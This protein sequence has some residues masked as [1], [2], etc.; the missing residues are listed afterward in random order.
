MNLKGAVTIV[1]G[2][3]SG[4]GAAA[5]ERLAGKGCRVVV[6]YSKSADGAEQ[7]AKK[8]R[9]AGSEAIVVKADVA[10]DGDCRRLAQAALDKWGRIDALI[11]NAGTTKF[12]S[13]ADLDALDAAD[14]Q[15]IYAVNVIGTYQMT[16]AVAPAMKKA[17]H[18]AVVN[19]S[20]IASTRGSGSS[21][22]YAA[23]KGALNT[24]TIG[25]ARSLAPEI[26]VNAILPGF[27]DSPW[28]RGGLGESFDQAKAR[29]EASAALG[30]AGTPEDMAEVAV[31]LIECADYVTGQLLPVEGGQL[32]AVSTAYRLPGKSR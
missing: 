24:L 23:S 7:V 15:R 29:V 13:A 27:F 26:R 20:S 30:R 5:A 1:T 19:V 16:R 18:G 32:L 28:L 25:L 3:S 4:L 11:N 22:A 31:A 12:A 2:S 10:D 9:A 14:F 6:N 17:G 21:L 8:C